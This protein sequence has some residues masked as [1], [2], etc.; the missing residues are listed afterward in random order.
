M[1]PETPQKRPRRVAYSKNYNRRYKDP[2]L[3][4]T[5]DFFDSL[6]KGCGQALAIALLVI[7]AIAIIKLSIAP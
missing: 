5:N 7:L 3:R 2:F 1:P 6:P 4:A